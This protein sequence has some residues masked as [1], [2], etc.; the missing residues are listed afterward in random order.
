MNHTQ[1][2]VRNHKA[3]KTGP[4]TAVA[5]KRER[6]SSSGRNSHQVE[7]KSSLGTVVRDYNTRL[8]SGTS[9]SSSEAGTPYKKMTSMKKI[10]ASELTR[11][12]ESAKSL[13]DNMESGRAVDRIQNLA[14]IDVKFN[15][16]SIANMSCLEKYQS[17]LCSDSMDVFKN[18]KF[19][20][21]ER[22][23][24]ILTEHINFLIVD[25]KNN[26]PGSPGLIVR[27]ENPFEKYSGVSEFEAA[28]QYLST[29]TLNFTEREGL[30]R[31]ANIVHVVFHFLDR[32]KHYANVSYLM[33]QMFTTFY[34][35]EYEIESI[36]NDSQRRN[37]IVLHEALDPTLEHLTFN[38]STNATINK[39]GSMAGL[40]S[41]SALKRNSKGMQKIR[42]KYDLNKIEW[43]KMMETKKSN[44]VSS[45]TVTPAVLQ[46]TPVLLH[47]D[48]LDNSQ[49]SPLTKE[50]I[51]FT[52]SGVD[53][54]PVQAS[55]SSF[56]TWG[57]SIPLDGD[58][59]CRS[60]FCVS[61]IDEETGDDVYSWLKPV[62]NISHNVDG[63][64]SCSG[65]RFGMLSPIDTA[66]LPLS[67]SPLGTFLG[68]PPTD[69]QREDDTILTSYG[70]RK[71]VRKNKFY[72]QQDWITTSPRDMS[73]SNSSNTS[74][75][76]ANSRSNYKS[77]PHHLTSLINDGSDKKEKDGK[78]S[79]AMRSCDSNETGISTG[80]STL[81]GL[82]NNASN[83]DLLRPQSL[84]Q[85]P[86]SMQYHRVS[87]PTDIDES[88]ASVEGVEIEEEAEGLETGVHLPPIGHQFKNQFS[89]SKPNSVFDTATFAAL[90]SLSRPKAQRQFSWEELPD[91]IDVHDMSEQSIQNL[92]TLRE[93]E[94]NLA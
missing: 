73:S 16:Y 80:N 35:T 69:I 94:V 89:Q 15:F 43:L 13:V 49:D 11:F 62:Q 12:D 6:P 92:Y 38:I 68:A 39:Y 56:A 2:K 44:A 8:N 77:S 59:S 72:G 31:F 41:Q 58:E 70:L 85:I 64:S 52:V 32:G 61:E 51:K 46:A 34:Q 33:K 36:E 88:S 42:E 30:C 5:V 50:K 3:K 7:K 1:N 71:T 4:F 60:V 26:I 93:E 27:P 81:P 10:L 21:Y 29:D 82:S 9:S 17:E 25:S 45:H 47:P 67:R 90:N 55:T 76:N 86:F 19:P 57:M 22:Y 48:S 79:L 75:S 91:T 63:S 84:P 28:Y 37:L 54:V 53:R 14:E 24:D 78:L 65:P 20:L 74:Y 83:N 18:V 23:L 66:S 87:L 40:H